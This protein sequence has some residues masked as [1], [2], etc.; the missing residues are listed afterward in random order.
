MTTLPSTKTLPELIILFASL[1]L[2]AN[3]NTSLI[4]KV[5]G[6][7]STIAWAPAEGFTV[8]VSSLGWIGQDF[9][10]LYLLRCLL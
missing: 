5:K 8:Q 6:I 10:A 1:E 9:G 2:S 4:T 7:E 3:F